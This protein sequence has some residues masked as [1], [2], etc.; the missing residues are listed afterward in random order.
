[1]LTI[2]RYDEC[3]CWSVYGVESGVYGVVYQYD[4]EQVVLSEELDLGHFGG[5][6]D[7]GVHEGGWEVG[8]WTLIGEK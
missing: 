1:M 3:C 6:V 4:D 8:C 2:G 7:V 5:N